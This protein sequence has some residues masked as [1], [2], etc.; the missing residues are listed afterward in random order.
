MIIYADTSFFVSVY[1]RDGHTPA[2]L[3]RLAL[4]PRIWLTPLHEVEFAHALSQNVFRGEI[5]RGDADEVREN[6]DRDCRAALWAMTD[7]PA[8]AFTSG[9]DLA[10]RYVPALGTR[11]LDTLH[12]A[13]ALE[14]KAER[15]WTF[16]ERQRKLARAAGLRTT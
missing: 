14:L 8:A 15:F 10:R 12:V 5:S 6:L 3:R 4:K 11:T 16:D 7:F 2:A 9:A 13:C 1:L